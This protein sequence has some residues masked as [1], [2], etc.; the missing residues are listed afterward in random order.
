MKVLARVFVAAACFA[1][2][3]CGSNT[4]YGNNAGY[5]NSPT[6]PA[7]PTSS[8]PPDSTVADQVNATEALAF[9]PATLTTQVG[10]TVVFS[11]ASIGHNVFFDAANG[12]P[13]DIPGVNSDTTVSRTFDTAGTFTYSCHIHPFM[14]GTVVVQ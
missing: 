8:T 4:G 6:S 5:G 11:F 10:H 3:G 12:V 13:A 9:T 2:G 1:A 7:S 14:R